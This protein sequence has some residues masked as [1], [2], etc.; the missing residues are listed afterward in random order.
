VFV[1]TYILTIR[2]QVFLFKANYGTAVPLMV[3]FLF[4]LF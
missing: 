3:L 4:K 2:T 1:R